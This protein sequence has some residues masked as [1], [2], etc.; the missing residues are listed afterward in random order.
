M[1]RLTRDFGDT[2]QRDVVPAVS[3]DVVFAS[4]W[5]PNYRIGANNKII[6]TKDDP[7]SAINEGGCCTWD[8]TV[9][10]TA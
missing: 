2:M 6:E 7:K 10:G 1:M 9:V 5:F 8:C 3:S 4:S